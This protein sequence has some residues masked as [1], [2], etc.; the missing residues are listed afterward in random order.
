MSLPPIHTLIPHQGS[1]CLLGKVLECSDEQICCETFSHLQADNPLRH[2]GQ[3]AAVHLCEYGAQA[4]ALHGPW[5]AALSG[6]REPAGGGYLAA[7]K[8]VECH[9]KRIDTLPAD[10]PMQITAKR[11]LKNSDGLIYAFE[12]RHGAQ[13]LSSGRLVVALE[14]N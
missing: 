5:L 13:L 8:S 7:L 4:A 14:R 9:V 6:A 3:L 11:L 2:N 1:M 10:I 12:A